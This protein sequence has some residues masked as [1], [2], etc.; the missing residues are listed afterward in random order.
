MARVVQVD[1]IDN[2]III[3]SDPRVEDKEGI[4]V[5]VTRDEALNRI[6]DLLDN[7]IAEK[8]VRLS[9]VVLP[10]PAQTNGPEEDDS[11]HHLPAGFGSEADPGAPEN[12]DEHDDYEAELRRL[13]D[14]NDRDA[15]H[16]RLKAHVDNAVIEP[17]KPRLGIK[18]LVDLIRQADK[19]AAAGQ[20]QQELP[21]TED[22]APNGR[23]PS[24]APLPDGVPPPT[25]H[26]PFAAQDDA[27]PAVTVQDVSAALQAAAKRTDAN[28]AF[29]VLKAHNASK[30]TDLNPSEFA[31]V[32]AE[33][34]AIGA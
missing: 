20:G 23:L 7:K 30:V 16:A 18:N 17:Y 25:G 4:E 29:G 1:V 10:A 13:V 22:D 8:K 12:Q 26:D 21:G 28:T 11:G 9:D 34:N 19:A 33:A 5:F 31:Q 24:G 6:A 15:A 32:I 2:G 27:A 3:Q 14:D